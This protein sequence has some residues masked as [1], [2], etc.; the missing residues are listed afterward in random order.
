MPQKAPSS[1]AR[2]FVEYDAQE[3][4]SS[5]GVSLQGHVLI[6]R[7]AA[8]SLIRPSFLS[9]GNRPCKLDCGCKTDY[10]AKITYLYLIEISEDNVARTGDHLKN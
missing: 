9:R 1:A 3:Q 5:E 6:R 8:P 4:I 7:G 10:L 2:R